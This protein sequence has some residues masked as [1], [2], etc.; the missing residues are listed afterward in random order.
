MIVI[1]QG[2]DGCENEVSR[3]GAKLFLECIKEQN[4][5]EE[6]E[7]LEFNATTFIDDIKRLNPSLVLNAMVGEWGED[8]RVPV[9]LDML[10]VKYTHSGFQASSAGM[11]KA[12]CKEIAEAIDIPVL[13]HKLVSKK[14]LLRDNINPKDRS[15]LKPNSK[16]SSIGIFVLDAGQA[17]S[18]EQLDIIRG[19]DDDYFLLEEYCRGIE[20]D[21]SVVGAKSV[22]SLE[23][24][25]D[26]VI[27]DYE[28]KYTPG[29]ARHYCPARTS[30]EVTAEMITFME[31]KTEELHYA[32]NCKGASRTNFIV[33]YGKCFFLEINT[34]PG[35]T[36][37][38]ILPETAQKLKGLSYYDIY[39]QIVE[40]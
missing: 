14:I 7:L 40:S 30:D 29:G 25:H 22:G 19:I 16:G 4:I 3:S 2:G 1:L 17:L 6:V 35:F 32:M 24:S 33:K 28:A 39:K 34:H 23:I 11:N 37:T 36:P 9:L 13:K 5:K 20:I 27:Y 15:V 18:K 12:F 8:G 10:N 31:A 38:S 21:I 26:S